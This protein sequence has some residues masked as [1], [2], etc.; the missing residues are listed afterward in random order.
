[1][2]RIPGPLTITE[3]V[4]MSLN[5]DVRRIVKES[6]GPELEDLRARVNA[7]DY[8][9]RAATRHAQWRNA[10]KRFTNLDDLLKRLTRL[11]AKYG[12]HPKTAA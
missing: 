9:Q 8:E 6:V 10:F 12:I 5:H 7:I 11:E 2:S 3:G 1:L 4:E